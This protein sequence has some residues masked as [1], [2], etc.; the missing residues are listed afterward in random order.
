MIPVPYDVLALI[1]GLLLPLAFAP[2]EYPF[3]AVVSLILLFAG[4]MNATPLRA[5]VRGYLFGLGQFGF[6]I[7]WVYVSIHDYGGTDVAVAAGLTTLFVAWWALYPALAGWL[8][9]RWFQG[10][11]G[12]R[13]IAVWPAVWV[14][15]E[16][17]RGWFITGFPWLHLGYSQLDTPLAGFAPVLGTYGVSW[18]VALLAGLL[19]T[20]PQWKGSGRRLVFIAIMALIGVAFALHRIEW[21]RPAGAPFQAALLQG[22]IPQDRKWQPDFQ[23]ETL[24]RYWLMTREQEQARLIV[25]PE[26]AV[27]GFYHQFKDTV[28]A[29]L[30]AEAQQRGGDL[31]IG[32]PVYAGDRYYNAL[33][34]LGAAPG[35]YFKR[36]L[37]PFGEYMPL[38]P[39]LGW[40]LD[41]VQI[42]MADFS[43]GR[44]DQP[45]LVAAGHPLAASVCYEDVFGN[46]S[47]AFLPEARYLVNV[48][49]DA[50][51]GDSIAPHQHAQMARMRSLE[52][53]RYMLR[54]TNTG[55]SAIITPKG[56]Y[57]AKAPLLQQ[58]TVTGSVT[59]MQGRT[60]YVWWGDAPVVVLLA[61]V[62]GWS[63]WRGRRPTPTQE[64]GGFGGTSP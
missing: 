47:R 22:N 28:L 48:T 16:W 54:A 18:A 64:T 40:V 39:L 44:N 52:T 57:A 6:G 19:L 23:R 26:T 51:F 35:L 11:R 37:V 20:A 30:Q 61:F 41:L 24:K 63:G 2:F 31:L 29:D 34:A 56:A 42:P 1:G 3:I 45:L 5:W 8:A 62:A 25:W 36:H 21:T 27:P 10:G 50:W 55:V 38:R 4:W 7:S 43:A 46:E 53:G 14:L 59:P 12:L 33:T 15:V 60:P 13:A 32:I 17:F 9:V 49:N 58:A